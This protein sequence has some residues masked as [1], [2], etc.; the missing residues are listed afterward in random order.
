MD[1]AR[2]AVAIGALTA[3]LAGCNAITS[4]GDLEFTRDPS[5]TSTTSGGDPDVAWVR[6]YGDAGEDFATAV[7]P[8]PDGSVLLAGSFAGTVDFGGGPL[9]SDAFGRDAFVVKVGPDGAHRLSKKFGGADADCPVRAALGPTGEVALLLGGGPM[10]LGCL[11]GAEG[12]DDPSLGSGNT[13]FRVEVLD[14]AGDS[15]ASFPLCS[16]CSPDAV[17]PRGIAFDASG[18][19]YVAGSF[20]G[21]LNLGGA[22]LVAAGFSDVFVAKFSPSGA[23]VYSR[24]FPA[25]AGVT[26][27]VTDLAVAPSGEA[28]VLGVLDGPLTFGA[29][30]L[31]AAY[32][33]VFVAKLDALGAPVWSKAVRNAWSFVAPRL[34]LDEAGGVFLAGDFAGEV[35]FGGGP[36][37]SGPADEGTTD[38]YVAKL[39]PDGAHLFSRRIG[40][41]PGPV[42]DLSAATALA[43]DPAGGVVVTGSFSG[44]IEAGGTVLDAI[45]YGDT[46]LVAFD[47]SGAATAAKRFGGAD[48]YQLDQLV[49]LDPDGA[50]LAAGT[51]SGTVDFGQG[52]A[53][54]EGDP[55]LLFDDAFLVKLALR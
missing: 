31:D 39:G 27:A 19:I 43:V 12:G 38:G 16:G 10:G 33:D 17:G 25:G 35:D 55:E 40:E 36:L 4:I 47:P 29:A 28:I 34:A 53:A 30:T 9:E 1:A 49:A 32:L 5:A 54:A 44:S 21:T 23:H 37:V 13:S 6:T 11:A 51:F 18:A 48:A 15:A 2:R 8:Y 20:A 24:A 3:A 7:V 50:V 22:D 41:A 52:P 14:A 45:G 42:R 26:A 46:F